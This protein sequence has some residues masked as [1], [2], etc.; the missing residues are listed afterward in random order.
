MLKPGSGGE[1]SFIQGED[2]LGTAEVYMD[3]ND[4]GFGL[5]LDENLLHGT[6]SPC[7]TFGNYSLVNCSD[8]GE[9]FDV[10]NLEIWTLT[11]SQTEREAER[12]EMSMFFVRESVSSLSRMSGSV[13]G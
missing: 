4:Y 7:A 2:L 1:S 11:S 8:S 10:M 3:I 12:A 5:A 13:S 6:S 9:T